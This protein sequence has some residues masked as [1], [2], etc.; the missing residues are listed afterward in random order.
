M[1]LTWIK[2]IH[3]TEFVSSSEYTEQ[4]RS[5][6]RLF[7]SEIRK[8]LKSLGASKIEI[9]RG[10]FESYG[11][12]TLNDKVWYF[13]LSDVRF[14]NPTYIFFIRKAKDYNDFT[15]GLN[16]FIKT[17]DEESFISDFRKIVLG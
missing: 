5:F 7:N 15:G 14:Y 17:S 1:P 12:F 4:F 3:N 8:F 11:F 2:K 13:S 6:Y 10:H 16:I 9:N